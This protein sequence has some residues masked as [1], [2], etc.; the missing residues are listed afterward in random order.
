MAEVARRQRGEAK[1]RLQRSAP[2][3]AVRT[4]PENPYLQGRTFLLAKSLD[5]SLISGKRNARAAT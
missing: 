5:V 3:S 1:K 4:R 2:D